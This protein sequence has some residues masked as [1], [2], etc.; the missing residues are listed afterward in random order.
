MTIEANFTNHGHYSETFTVAVFADA[1]EIARRTIFLAIG[2]SMKVVFT[3]STSGFP[4]SN[5]TIGAAAFFLPDEY[6]IQDNVM[7]DIEVILGAPCDVTGPE[8]PLGSGQYPPDG[9]CNMRDIG[10]IAGKFG[11]TP[12][13][14]N[15][16]PNCDMTGPIA[17]VPDDIVDMRDIGDACN[18]F[19]QS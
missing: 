1:M 11:T 7:E 13:G 17:R 15:W 18:H 3:W 6:D 14:P 4:R 19:G 16:D 10:Y 8:N 9:V 5:Y 2:E 12:I